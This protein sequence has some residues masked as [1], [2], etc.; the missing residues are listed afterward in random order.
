MKGTPEKL[1]RLKEGI[2]K[3]KNSIEIEN[4]LDR[5]Y[6]MVKKDMFVPYDPKVYPSKF[7]ESG[8]LKR[9]NEVER[10]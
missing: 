3:Q 8:L 2:P 9:I 6:S 5:F 10:K 4:C 7:K 1:K